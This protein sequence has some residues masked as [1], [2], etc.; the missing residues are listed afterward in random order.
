ME[1]KENS[2]KTSYLFSLAF[3]VFSM[4]VPLITTPYV[5]RI[6][7]PD[8]VGAYSFTNSNVTYFTLIGVLGLGTYGQLEVAKVKNSVE[9][10]S[11]LFFEIMTIRGFT[12]IVAI[13]LYSILIIFS[14]KYRIMYLIQASLLVASV[15]DITWFFQGI[16][17]FKRVAIRNIVIKAASVGLIFLFVKSKND[18]YLYTIILSASVLLSSLCFYPY[19]KKYIIKGGKDK[20]E[21]KKHI[22][23][24]CVFFIPTIASIIMTSLDKTM[25][26]LITGSEEENG[27]YA[28]AYK[29][30]SLC[31]TIFSSLNVVMRSRM[32]FLYNSNMGKEVKEL[33]SKSVQFVVF[34]AFPLCFGL[35]SITNNFVPWF[36]GDGYDKVK[37][38]LPIFSFWL[39][40]KAQSNCLLEQHVMVSGRQKEFNQ[41]IWVGTLCNVLLNSVLICFIDSI[42]AAIA[43][44]ISECVIFIL[45]LRA[46]R[47][48]VTFSEMIEVAWKYVVASATMAVVVFFVGEL[49]EASVMSTVIQIC[50]GFVSYFVILI[51]MH[52]R[53]V[54]G[55][56]NKFFRGRGRIQ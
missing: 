49:F 24:T 15:F 11:K 33:L 53:M 16:E 4:I 22:K 26:G 8:G 41:I 20:K 45:A 17:E 23:G 43:S 35:I 52:D 46:C 32:A 38:I 56:L 28:Q 29:I 9:K 5:S 36:F 54:I 14:E 13:S 7:G 55:I 39:I 30:E 3:Q 50:V 47:K 42:G 34:L 31:F 37:V 27:Y 1:K 18:L 12:H 25:I 48:V 19:L 6:L 21:L 40:F 44:V 2:I 10:R 51:I